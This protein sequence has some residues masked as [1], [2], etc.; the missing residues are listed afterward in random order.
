PALAMRTEVTGADRA[1]LH[2]RAV[3]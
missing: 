2:V 1:K 3:G